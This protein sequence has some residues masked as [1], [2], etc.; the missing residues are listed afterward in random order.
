MKERKERHTDRYGDGAARMVAVCAVMTALLL[1]VQCALSF[2]A[3]VELV[4]A[5]LLVFCYVF[6]AK[7]GMVTATAFS[8][9]R[10]FIFGFA[11][12]VIAL[13]LIYFNAFALVFGAM[14]KRRGHWAEYVCPA[15]VLLLAA[16]ALALAILGLPVSPLMAARLEVMLWALFAVLLAL[17]V[18]SVVLLALGGR[19][20]IGRE[21]AVLASLAAFCTVCFTLLSD[22]ITP[23]FYGWSIDVAI[24]YFYTGFFAMV[25]QTLCAAVSVTLLFYPLERA[26]FM[27]LPPVRKKRLEALLRARMARKRGG[28]EQI[29]PSNDG[30]TQKDMV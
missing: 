1:A 21:A 12:D 28:A 27:V 15:L 23:L 16:G 19:V 18:G 5:F 8:L 13:Y 29:P 2:V 25:P 6:G 7:Y 26:F 3:G 14:G 22:V 20:R 9:L 10:N 30:R 11:P 24:G 4:T 17:F